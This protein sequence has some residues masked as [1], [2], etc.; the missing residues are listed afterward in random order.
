MSYFQLIIRFFIGIFFQTFYWVTEKKKTIENRV[1]CVCSTTMQKQLA[2]DLQLRYRKQVDENERCITVFVFIS[3]S[4][5]F[6][7]LI[8]HN[9]QFEIGFVRKPRRY[10][11]VEKPLCLPVETFFIVFNHYKENSHRQPKTALFVVFQCCSSSFLAVPSIHIIVKQC[12][13]RLFWLKEV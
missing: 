10:V 5:Y 7:F 3:R 1:K 11:N 8:D 12:T 2:P 6:L 4:R 13:I 9:M